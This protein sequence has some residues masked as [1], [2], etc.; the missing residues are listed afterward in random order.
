MMAGQEAVASTGDCGTHDSHQNWFKRTNPFANKVFGAVPSKLGANLSCIRDCDIFTFPVS[1]LPKVCG[2]GNDI[3]EGEARAWFDRVL[4]PVFIKAEGLDQADLKMRELDDIYSKAGLR[5]YREVFAVAKENFTGVAGAALA[6]RGPLGLNLT[7]LENRCDILLDP[8]LGMDE[9]TETI[10]QLLSLAAPVYSDFELG[11][12]PVVVNSGI[13]SDLMPRA[14]GEKVVSY[15]QCCWL[16]DGYREM[17]RHLNSVFDLS[18]R[19][20]RPMEKPGDME[21]PRKSLEEPS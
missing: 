11:W 3:S 18:R 2:G 17:I 4:H 19:S 8:S 7:F 10:R 13:C 14:G 5:R 16:K 12:I 9:A 20:N 6:Y 15:A 1:S 21:V